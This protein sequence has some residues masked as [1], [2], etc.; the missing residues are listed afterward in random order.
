MSRN[1]NSGSMSHWGTFAST[2]RMLDKDTYWVD[3]DGFQ[4]CDVTADVIRC[5][6]RP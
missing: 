2:F 5:A 6:Q 1:V 3:I 4:N